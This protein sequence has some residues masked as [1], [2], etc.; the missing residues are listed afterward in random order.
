VCI[1]SD[2]LGSNGI[3]HA[4]VW[5]GLTDA[6]H[7]APRTADNLAKVLLGFLL[8]C[9]YGP[10]ALSALRSMRSRRRGVEGALVPGASRPGPHA[11]ASALEI[12][13]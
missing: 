1:G 10:L 9:S 11:D 2:Y 8:G 13:S 12:F 3:G 5:G 6:L 7:I 4:P